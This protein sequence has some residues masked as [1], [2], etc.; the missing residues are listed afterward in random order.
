MSILADTADALITALQ[1]NG[2]ATAAKAYLPVIRREDCETQHV[3][4][5]P[6]GQS[7]EDGDRVSEDRLLDLRIVIQQAVD[8][9][10]TDAVE[11]LLDD[12]DALHALWGENGDLRD[13][14]LNG[15]EWEEGPKHPD[16]N[17]YDPV[18]LHE[19]QIFTSVTAIIYRR[20]AAD[21]T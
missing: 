12:V 8:P 15:A 9:T 14:V 16:G 20:C 5:I 2:F 17:A 4:V 21:Q 6:R 3:L 18:H 19:Y 10:D 11:A 1:S 13:V 7:W